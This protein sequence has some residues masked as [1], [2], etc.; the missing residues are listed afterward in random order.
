VPE[1]S[2][3]RKTLV[4][5]TAAFTSSLIMLDSNVVAVALPTI[6]RE[7]HAGFGGIQWVISAYL[8][9]FGALLLPAGSTAD[10][11][12]RRRA[13]TI[14]LV[15]F[16]LASIACGLA[17][18]IAALEVARAIQG[19]GGSLLLTAALAIISSTFALPERPHAYAF[20]GTCI[21]VSMTSGPIVGG[22]ITGLLG[23]RWTFLVNVPLCLAF[24]GA[25][26]VFVP[27]S[28]DRDARR[29]D[30]LGVATSATALFALTWALIEGN[31]I[32]WTNPW[33]LASFGAS[34]VLLAAFV[35][36]ESAQ[37]RPMVDLRV[38]ARRTFVG[39]AFGTVGYG[40]AAQV[41]IFLLPLVLQEQFGFA[42]LVAGFAML[43]FAVPLFI[44][45]RLA[46]ARVGHWSHRRTLVSALA[47]VAVGD[48]ALALSAPS[49]AYPL[50]AVAMLIVGIGTG[51]LNPETAKATQAQVPVGRAGMGSGIGASLRFASLNV[52][53]ALLGLL[54]G[55]FPHDDLGFVLASLVAA[56]LA[57]GSALLVLNLM[58]VRGQGA[59][60]PIVSDEDARHGRYAT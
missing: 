22:L 36:V 58:R 53:V 12:G 59:V 4:L 1:L 54:V 23:W 20:W 43:P 45:P 57:L 39:A 55:A 33:I 41:M 3:R 49:H 42:P 25:M 17:T 28:S 10:L 29:V 38:V 26:A 46:A 60:V 8:V 50:F 6:A 16:L 31:R 47:V 34:V 44:A 2:A 14:G 56:A 9:T 37:T 51:V 24:L 11:I 18:S 32:G 40:T 5:I 7:L 27:E 15:I 52:G 35:A 30:A 19:I 21:G 13:A 48:L